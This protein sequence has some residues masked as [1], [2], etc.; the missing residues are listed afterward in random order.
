I[1]CRSPSA[2][3][4]IEVVLDDGT[5]QRRTVSLSTMPE[6]YYDDD[7][8]D[9]PPSI[10]GNTPSSNSS[11]SSTSSDTDAAD[12]SLTNLKQRTGSENLPFPQRWSSGWN[13]LKR[14]CQS[15]RQYLQ[16]TPE[17]RLVLKCSFAYFLASLFTFIPRLNAMVGHNR[18]SS[19][20]I[21]TAT[22]F[23]NPAKTLGGMVE[24]A[25]YGWG[26]VIFALAICMG[27][28]VTTDFFIDRHFIVTAHAISLMLWLA[29]ATFAIAFL[30]AH[31]NKPPVATASSLCFIIIFIVVVRE[32]SAN[33]GDFDTTRIEQITTAVA[34]GTLITV[35]SCILFWPV[36][37]AKKLR[38]DLEATLMSYKVL[39]KLLTKTFLLD[40]DLPEFKANATLQ[41]AIDSHRASFTA[42]QK[43]L[44]EAKLEVA[45]N[46]EMRGRVP[47]YDRVVTSMQRLAQYVGGLKSSCGLQFELM[48]IKKTKKGF[49]RSRRSQGSAQGPN[50]AW[51]I[52]AGYRR[53][54]LEDEMRR[55]K[56]MLSSPEDDAPEGWP[57]HRT[58]STA[59]GTP[60]TLHESSGYIHDYTDTRRDG[61][62]IEFIQTIR[63]PLKSLAYTCKQTLLHLQL[64]FSTKG[65]IYADETAPSFE[66][67]KTNLTKAISLF[68]V[69]QRQAVERLH[70]HRLFHTQSD[71]G[72]PLP[73]T[74]IDV[75]DADSYAPGEEMFL[76]YFFVFNMIEFAR[77]L[78]NLVEAVGQLAEKA[79]RRSSVWSWLK[80]WRSFTSSK[81]HRKVPLKGFIPNERHTVNT[82][83]T[84]QPK[85]QW[86]RF[87]IRLW[88]F[89]SLFK[90]QKIRY[91]TKATVATILLAV[92]A[93][94]EF[95]GAWFREWRMEWALITLMVVMTPT[96]GGT[97]QVAVYRIFSTVL[98]CCSAMVLYLLF[99][100][101]MYI[102]PLV[103]W[104]FSIPNFWII[105][106]H[107]HGKFGQFTLLA[108]NL[109]MLNK[110]NDREADS[111]E[112]WRLA[113]Q[114]CLAIL[115]GV[116]FGLVATA[117]IWPYEAR[118]ELRKGLS[119][120][121][122]RLGWLYQELVSIYSRKPHARRSFFLLVD[123][124]AYA[125]EMKEL[126]LEEQRRIV[127]RIFM[128]LE[129]GLQR[130]LLDLHALLA[131]TP[132]E[133]RLKG[134]FP[135]DTYREM[136]RSCQNIVDKFLSIRTI[137][138]KDAWFDEVQRDFIAPISQENREMI[139][140]VL[141]YFY[142][143]ASALRLKT[144]LPPYLPPAR[145]AW[146]SLITRLR[147]LPVVQSKQMLEKDHI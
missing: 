85:T 108:Y 48:N 134:A 71:P 18:T 103:T 113:L 22:V 61:G 138:L 99:P 6:A 56:L 54:R 89:L 146:Q 32:G 57:L 30:K 115:V 97:N 52:K 68:E 93:F 131:Q 119:D 53:R 46:Q 98:G 27:S 90:T 107:K 91:A 17:Q 112:V 45:W 10:N 31:W 109:V 51:N 121:L 55:Q 102:L 96:V 76:V 95:S 65:C 106:N 23:F 67:L 101:N 35:S 1:S 25:A 62:L 120:F 142:L 141:L 43:S 3:S 82:L 135:V 114:R 128:D 28:M 40:D 14:R 16:I 132:N 145:K 118:V 136:L 34:T 144:P 20:L 74:N 5:L 9:H 66:T 44:K 15:Y 42:L 38:K 77:E 125:P 81:Q 87:F 12:A 133:P 64:C 92:P 94:L 19:H 83:H 47:E 11:S 33:K 105:L 58:P 127:T 59:S 41:K 7:Q 29:G 110:Y 86:R 8:D 13:R 88:W 137:I 130:T 63:Q 140:N 69:S 143:L 139:G 124:N 104:L 26:Y 4:E 60:S 2:Y 49:F 84:P 73:P 70:R 111:I 147:Q 39:L 122:L 116:L 100:G 126:P 79:K 72:F 37:A 129:L 78:I 24:A 36:S 80:T 75:N 117:Y 123:I 50:K 21:A